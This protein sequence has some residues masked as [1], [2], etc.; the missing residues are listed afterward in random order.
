MNLIG[1]LTAS[2]VAMAVFLAIG[3]VAAFA[4]VSEQE[5]TMIDN[6]YRQLGPVAAFAEVSGQE[7]SDAEDT[8]IQTGSGDDYIDAV[9]DPA[10]PT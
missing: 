7:P 2:V 1:R 10:A 4:E 6:Q 8:S 5:P 9:D 3:A